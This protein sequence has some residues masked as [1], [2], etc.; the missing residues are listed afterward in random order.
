M[1]LPLTMSHR[2]GFSS[3]IFSSVW[4]RW[5]RFC[6][7]VAVW[8]PW[9]CIVYSFVPL[10][11]I[12]SRHAS[13]FT[14]IEIGDCFGS[15]LHVP[16]FFFVHGGHKIS[17]AFLLFFGVPRRSVGLTRFRCG[18]CLLGLSVLSWG[19]FLWVCISLI[20][21]WIT[22]GPNG[23]IIFLSLTGNSGYSIYL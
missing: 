9:V 15:K 14:N 19:R 4:T 3:S 17:L 2:I 7:V 1:P 10:R 23:H 20:R 18:V 5:A 11:T 13:N 22:M 12:Y 8:S 16:I 21:V 6:V